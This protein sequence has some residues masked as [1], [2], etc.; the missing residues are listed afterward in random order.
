MMRGS[1][2]LAI[3][4]EVLVSAPALSVATLS[5]PDLTA[6]AG[7]GTEAGAEVDGA[8]GSGEA[9]CACAI[10]QAARTVAART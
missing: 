2:S 3:S 6:A 4:A 8:D 1:C 10:W 5:A 9:V 7:A